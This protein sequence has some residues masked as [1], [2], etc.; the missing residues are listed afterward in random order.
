MADEVLT[1]RLNDNLQRQVQEDLLK[2]TRDT[3]MLDIK[4]KAME[5][6]PVTAEGLKYNEAKHPKWSL[7]K[8][9]GTGTNRR[10]IDVT[11]ELRDGKIK[12]E[13]FTQSGY[14]GYLESG[15][16]KMRAQPYLWPAF[17]MYVDKIKERWKEL[18]HG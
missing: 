1:L 3:F 13:L 9:G 2:A 16:S 10:S 17:R 15:T 14:G 7:S 11:V 4:P 18:I 6:S 5:L 8:V 12:A